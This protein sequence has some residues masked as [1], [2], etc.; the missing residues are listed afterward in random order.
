MPAASVAPALYSLA[1]YLTGG[2]FAWWI[3]RQRR[4]A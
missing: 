2:V 4:V 3:L 1:M